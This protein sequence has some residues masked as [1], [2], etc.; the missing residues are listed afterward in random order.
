MLYGFLDSTVQTEETWVYI[1][2]YTVGPIRLTLACRSIINLTSHIKTTTICYI[3][4][5]STCISL[6][7]MHISCKLMKPMLAFYIEAISVNL[8]HNHQ[9]FHHLSQFGWF[10]VDSVRFHRFRSFIF[11][12]LNLTCWA[13]CHESSGSAV[14]TCYAN[15]YSPHIK[16]TLSRY[17]HVSEWLNY[18]Y[19]IS[20][21]QDFV[22]AS[23]AITHWKLD[24][25]KDMA[26]GGRKK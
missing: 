22:S 16:A 21:L 15:F 18:S 25:R 4:F 20:F 24:D 14:P 8:T 2:I 13:W 9:L 23:S 12:S 26:I 3:C 1:Y 7:I 11:I 19:K 10:L 17:L 5:A 6:E